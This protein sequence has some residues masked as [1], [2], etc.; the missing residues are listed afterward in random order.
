[1]RDRYSD[2]AALSAFF[3]TCEGQS[4]AP[5]GVQPVAT[6]LVIPG[7]SATAPPLARRRPPGFAASAARILAARAEASAAAKVRP[8]ARGVS[9]KARLFSPSGTGAPR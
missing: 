4:R 1:M 5:D 6:P 9:P 3:K 2:L 8:A 7:R